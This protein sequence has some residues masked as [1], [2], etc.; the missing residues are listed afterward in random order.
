[1]RL[2]RR[3]PSYSGA[4]LR[5]MRRRAGQGFVEYILVL[6]VGVLV[7]VTPFP[8]RTAPTACANKTNTAIGCLIDSMKGAY[9]GYNFAV[10]RPVYMKV[11]PALATA[12]ACIRNPGGSSCTNLAAQ[13]AGYGLTQA[14]DYLTNY[15]EDEISNLGNTAFDSILSWTG[16]GSISNLAD[17]F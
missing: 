1:M 16:F 15:V 11:N 13:V 10:S 9:S 5:R 3:V 12:D 2:M 6:A 17:I 7:L 14:E 4:N 8:S